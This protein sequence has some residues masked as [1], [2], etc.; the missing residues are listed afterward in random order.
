ME[1]ERIFLV[2]AVSKFLYLN[3]GAVGTVATN[4]YKKI[5]V[6]TIKFILNVFFGI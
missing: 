3:I 1:L 5:Q 4:F 2:K 6:D